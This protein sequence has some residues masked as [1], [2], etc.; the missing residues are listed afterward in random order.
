MKTEHCR[1]L[2]PGTTLPDITSM[3]ISDIILRF[4]LHSGFPLSPEK[5]IILVD[6]ASFLFRAY[7]AMGRDPLTTSDGRTTQAIFGMVNML[8]SLLRER[9]PTHIAVIMDAKGKNFRH[10][11]YS[12]Y[13]ANR[14]PH[15]GRPPGAVAV[16][17]GNNPGHGYPPDFHS[18]GRG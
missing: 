13:K 11:M 7:H 3:E 1:K 16:R 17:A 10:E 14:P 18:R 2:I 6:G 15:A 5:E 9:Q 4:N 8:K 12:E